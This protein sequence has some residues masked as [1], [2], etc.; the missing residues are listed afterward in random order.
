MTFEARVLFVIAF[1]ALWGVLGFLCWTAVAVWRRGRG[2]LPALPLSLLG[3]CLGGVALPVV[4]G[5]RDERGLMLSILT[6]AVGGALGTAGGIYLT[7]WQE[8]QAAA[9]EVRRVAGRRP[10]HPLDSD[11]EH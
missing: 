3:A 11:H 4:G 5:A 1:F 10:R 6:A 8:E 2:V 9:G 7:G